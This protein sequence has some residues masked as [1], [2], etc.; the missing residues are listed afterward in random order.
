MES[1]DRMWDGETGLNQIMEG[2]ECH[3]AELE[4]YPVVGEEP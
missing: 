1:Y 3:T 2:L 4:L